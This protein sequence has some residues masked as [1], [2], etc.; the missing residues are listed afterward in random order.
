MVLY[1]CIIEEQHK[2]GD[3]KDNAITYLFDYLD[4]F[5]DPP[6]RSFFDKLINIFFKPVA[7][8]DTTFVNPLFSKEFYHHDDDN[9]NKLWGPATY[10]I[11]NHPL[12]LMVRTI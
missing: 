12:M 4:D 6:N 7:S 10:T 9:D 2:E 1:Q 11:A 5:Q 3:N 8:V